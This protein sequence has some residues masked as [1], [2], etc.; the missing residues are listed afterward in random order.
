MADLVGPL[1][2]GWPQGGLSGLFTEKVP[3]KLPVAR[4]LYAKHIDEDASVW[5]D[6]I[7]PLDGKLSAC[8]TDRVVNVSV[9][10]VWS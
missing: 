5:Q 4:W 9:V 10:K 7:V 1:P 3:R 6:K 2:S 8:V